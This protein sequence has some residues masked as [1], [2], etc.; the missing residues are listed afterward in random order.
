M[1]VHA[2]HQAR[3]GGGIAIIFAEHLNLLLSEAAT[4]WYEEPTEI[5]LNAP[6]LTC[7]ALCFLTLINVLGMAASARFAI[8]LTSL[9]YTAITG[10]IV[11]GVFAAI[12]E[13]LRAG[14]FWEVRADSLRCLRRFRCSRRSCW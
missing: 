7:G 4:A 9:K 5:C 3:R 8:V 14:D 13:W 11:L 10:I 1:D 6:L 12:R 2:D